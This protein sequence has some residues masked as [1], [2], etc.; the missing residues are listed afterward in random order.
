MTKDKK[1]LYLTAFAVLA[2]LLVVLFVHTESSKIITACLLAVVA[3]IV[4]VTIKKR[5]AL[6]INK[7]EVLLVSIVLATIFVILTQLSGIFFGFYKNPYFVNGKILLTVILPMVTIIVTTELIR[8]VLLA[9][10][11]IFHMHSQLLADVV[12]WT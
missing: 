5:H 10:K 11:N 1:I 9:Q 6:S 7:K 12:M 8:S 3:P 4:C 2:A